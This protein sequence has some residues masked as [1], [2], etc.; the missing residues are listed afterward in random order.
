MEGAKGMT[1]EEE[2]LWE[3]ECERRSILAYCWIA[4]HTGYPPDL[5]EKALYFVNCAPDS[6]AKSM[7]EWPHWYYVLDHLVFGYAL[8]LG[9][10]WVPPR[11]ALLP[12]RATCCGPCCEK[13]KRHLRGI[14]R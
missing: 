2:D 7:Q 10:W 9:R 14:A 6:F 1:A 3:R 5:I 8:T 11:Q 13:E 12:E 4:D